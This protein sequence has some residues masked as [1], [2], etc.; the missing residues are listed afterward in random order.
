MKGLML[1]RSENKHIWTHSIILLVIFLFA[2]YIRFPNINRPLSF[3]HE[4]LTAHMLITMQ[5]W[6]AKGIAHYSFSPVFNFSNPE[7]KY[8]IDFPGAVFDSRGNMYYLSYGPLGFWLPYFIFKTIGVQPDIVPLQIFN[9]LIHFIGAAFVYFT[10]LLFTLRRFSR[11]AYLPSLLGASGYIFTAQGLWFGSNVYFSDMLVQL[12]WIIATYLI[13]RLAEKKSA[14][15]PLQLAL[16]SVLVG[17]MIFTE[18]LGVFYA[19]VVALVALFYFRS[20]V[21]FLSVA[22]S[23]LAAGGFIV[24]IYSSIAGFD[25]LRAS[26]TEKYMIRNSSMDAGGAWGAIISP[27]TYEAIANHYIVGYYPVLLLVFLF[28]VSAIFIHKKVASLLSREELLFVVLVGI[29]IVMHHLAFSNFT[30]IHD[31]S[32]FKGS[33]LLAVLFG[34]FFAH[35]AEHI[36]TNKRLL[37]TTAVFSVVFILATSYQQYSR[38]NPPDLRVNT[39]YTQIGQ[40]IRETA[41]PDETVFMQGGYFNP[42]LT[43]SA[44]RSILNAGSV[45]EAQ[46]LLKQRGSKK[47]VFYIFDP[48]GN[49]VEMERITAQ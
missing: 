36:Q 4:W 2:L 37:W 13:L 6:D 14:I 27:S 28:G 30:I 29:P 7:D 25:K 32:V 3:H 9:M 8:P 47:G 41:Q 42:M 46:M 22:L 5:S 23:S 21:L 24:G 11:R 40:A 35:V 33:F 26:M 49:L 48:S 39:Y 16:I 38:D 44:K 45:E 20:I 43:F 17:L 31:F 15:P 19:F 12:L 10:I 34:L 1:F 18:W